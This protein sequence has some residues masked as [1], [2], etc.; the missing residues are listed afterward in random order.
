MSF[1]IK[2]QAALYRDHPVTYRA[3][4][5]EAALRMKFGGPQ[6]ARSQLEHL[7]E[8]SERNG[9]TVRVIPF[10]AG[11]FPGSGQSVCYAHGPVPRL[12]TVQLDQS[13]G[14]VMSHVKGGGHDPTQLDLLIV[15]QRGERLPARRRRRPW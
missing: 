15:L 7:L 6:V 2:R 8:T 12:G 4:V 11:A 3:V 13:H 10:D 1:R 14:S 5:H 9:I